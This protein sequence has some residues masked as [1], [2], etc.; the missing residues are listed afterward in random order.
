VSRSVLYRVAPDF[1]SAGGQ[2]GIALYVEGRREDGTAGPGVVGFQSFVQRSGHV[3]TY[4]MEGEDL[5]RR[6]KR[7]LVAFYGAFQVPEMMRK[8][9][10]IL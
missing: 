7:G 6:L 1:D 3:Q 4:D 5:N 10:V 8:E 9:H 2:S